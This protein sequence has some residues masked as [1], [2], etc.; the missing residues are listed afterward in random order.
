M[1]HWPIKITA[2]LLVVSIVFAPMPATAI[3]GVGD[4]VFDPTNFVN[5]LET[6]VRLL[7]MVG[8]AQNQLAMME[9]NLARLEN[10]IDMLND[11]DLENLKKL[12]AISEN[13]E[14]LA[15]VVNTLEASFKTLYPD[16]TSPVDAKAFDEMQRQWLTQT[17]ESIRKAMAVQG[18]VT[19]L[20]DDR[21]DLESALTKARE[22]DGNLR[23]SQAAAE[24]N[25]ITA[26]QLLRL[27]HMMAVS[28]RAKAAQM[29]EENA[30]Q[31]AQTRYHDHLMQ[32]W[33]ERS[34]AT[35]L[36]DFP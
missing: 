5:T 32:G 4:I 28:E 13:A 9:A 33:S 12:E 20:K 22:A 24:I 2:A 1:K 25:G 10:L 30:R 18:G 34:T 6:A 27:Q 3:F 35:P 21:Q 31:R 23:I 17:R 29:A 7:K 14:G 8:I 16:F 15:Y 19:D 26:K 11:P 36:S